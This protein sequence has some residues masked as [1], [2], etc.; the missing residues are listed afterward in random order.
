ML[1]LAPR[2]VL[3]W[4]REFRRVDGEATWD[5]V[6]R[7]GGAEEEESDPYLVDVE[8]CVRVC[9]SSSLCVVL[10]RHRDD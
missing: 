6:G 5:A 1:V 4:L 2:P 10:F 9:V 8:R 7:S 3:A